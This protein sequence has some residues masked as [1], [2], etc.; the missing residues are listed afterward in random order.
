MKNWVS[1]MQAMVLDKQVAEHDDQTTD[2]LNGAIPEIGE[3]NFL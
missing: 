1:V 2:S 3:H